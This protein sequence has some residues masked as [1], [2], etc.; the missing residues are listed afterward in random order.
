[1]AANQRAYT[2][3]YSYIGQPY[4]RPDYYSQERG[5]AGSA[6]G[7][8]GSARSY[9][10]SQG[11]LAPKPAPRPERKRWPNGRPY[12][13]QTTQRSAAAAAIPQAMPRVEAFVITHAMLAK[14]VI[15][16]LV[17][18]AI[19]IGTILMNAKAT[20]IKYEI[21][22]VQNENVLLADEISMLNVKIEGARSIEQIEAYA[23]D[24]L[25]MK[26]PKASQCIYV[27]E[28]QAASS[29]LAATIKQKAYGTGKATAST[30]NE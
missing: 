19:L 6:Y 17:C 18:G 9:A 29:D 22:K 24:E 21:N 20:E 1:M 7:K 5:Q 26:Y 2:T 14:A 12:I 10:S 23:K 3:E 11:A 4:V 8:V 30:A 28:G 15:L 13:P 25:G 16:L 27:E